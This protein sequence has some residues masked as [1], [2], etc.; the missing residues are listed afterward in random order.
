MYYGR[1]YASR[2]QVVPNVNGQFQITLLNTTEDDIDLKRKSKV[3]FVHK[4]SLAV[5]QVDPTEFIETAHI[6]TAVSTNKPKVNS[7]K[8][9]GVT[10]KSVLEELIR[11]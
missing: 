8:Q 1:V 3:G 7:G 9:L 11:D 4:S 2:A 5:A 6:P 10:E